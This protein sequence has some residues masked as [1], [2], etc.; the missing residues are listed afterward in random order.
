M[1]DPQ[2]DDF[3]LGTSQRNFVEKRP[4]IDQDDRWSALV[5]LNW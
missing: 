1:V 2:I 4:R 3:P 5:G